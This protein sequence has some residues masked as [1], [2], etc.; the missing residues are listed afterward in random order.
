MSDPLLLVFALVIAAGIAAI[1]VL[2]VRPK[3]PQADPAAQQRISDLTG[4]VQAMGQMLAGA[5]AR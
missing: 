3:P 4:Q 2:L 5:Q 1:I